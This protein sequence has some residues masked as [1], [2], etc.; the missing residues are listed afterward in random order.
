MDLFDEVEEITCP[1]LIVIGMEGPVIPSHH[2]I[3]AA[4]KLE[5]VTVARFETS[6]HLPFGESPKE[7]VRA[8]G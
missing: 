5:N 6:G 3:E 1:V 7:F 4:E 8:L 2:Q